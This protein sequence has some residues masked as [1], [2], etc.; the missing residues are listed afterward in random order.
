[1]K[2]PKLIIGIVVILVLLII[3]YLVYKNSKKITT[4]KT[5]TSVQQAGLFDTLINLFKPK[6]KGTGTESDGEPFYCKIFPKLCGH[7][8]YCDC[9]NPGYTTDGDI[10]SLCTEG[11][12]TKWTE[13]C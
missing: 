9:E 5:G 6:P 10:S 7:K 13:E 3:F 1:M 8:K 4:V 2:N 11:I 12:G